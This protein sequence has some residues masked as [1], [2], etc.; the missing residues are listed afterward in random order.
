LAN[1]GLAYK[2]AARS[3]K[4]CTIEPAELR[5]EAVIAL[6]R[7]AISFD[8]GRGLAFSTY[9]WCVISHHLTTIIRRH[10]C[11]QQSLPS[12]GGNILYRL[13]ARDR[14]GIAAECS[15]DLTILDDRERCVLQRVFGLDRDEPATLAEIAADLGVCRKTVTRLRDRALARLRLDYGLAVEPAAEAA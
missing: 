15:P 7:A 13:A 5:Q 10:C 3:A 6:H 12:V 2:L 11:R 4:G 1:L 14:D 8:P 9:A